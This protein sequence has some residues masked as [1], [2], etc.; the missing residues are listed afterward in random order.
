MSDSS[1]HPALNPLAMAAGKSPPNL[2]PQ[3]RL[4]SYN[5]VPL[6]AVLGLLASLAFT[7]WCIRIYAK[8]FLARKVGWDDL[9]C[10]LG[11]VGALLDIVCFGIA[12]IQGPLGKH[13]WN[14][15]LAELIGNDFSVTLYI[16][17]VTGSG[18][19]GLIKLAIFLFY[20]DIFWPL[21]WCRW[22]IY[23]G[24]SLSSAFYLSITVVQFYFMTPRPG[25]T[26]PK[27]LSGRTAA[28]V[29]RLGIPTSSVGLAIDILLLIIPLR[30]VAQLQ[31]AR[32]RKIRLYIIFLVGIMATIGSILSLSFKIKTYGNPDLTYHLI[33]VNFFVAVEMSL[34]I[35]IASLPLVARA[36]K[37]HRRQL[38]SM[39]GSLTSPFLRL[40]RTL[41][42]R[43]TVDHKSS[44]IYEVDHESGSKNGL[45]ELGMPMQKGPS[46]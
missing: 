20:L 38:V 24:A 19:L 45:V 18:T 2:S 41:T 31:L 11:M 30:A 44:A 25:E 37:Q 13:V 36:F 21:D 33:L 4:S 15:S 23:I 40:G 10:T 39:A 9:V 32:K 46:M 22:A 17:Q 34:G 43:S 1:S 7:F 16:M 3:D 29:N 8:I 6:T 14:I 26:L 5:G 27:H 12:S 35:C 28:K 42:A